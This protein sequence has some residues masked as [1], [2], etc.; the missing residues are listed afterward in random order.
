M[1]V[2]KLYAYKLRVCR[3]FGTA[4]GRQNGY[5]CGHGRFATPSANVS[6]L[7]DVVSEV[8]ALAVR[9]RGGVGKETRTAS[10]VQAFGSVSARG[11]TSG[12]REDF[13]RKCRGKR[14]RGVS[15]CGLDATFSAGTSISTVSG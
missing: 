7:S 14:S 15:E 9:C 2:R 10:C 4:R 6:W 13:L 1:Q 5:P 11:K 8:A 3:I 12:V